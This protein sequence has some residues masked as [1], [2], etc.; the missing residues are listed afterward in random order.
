MKTRLLLLLLLPSLCGSAFGSSIGADLYGQ[1]LA[2]TATGF[3]VQMGEIKTLPDLGFGGIFSSLPSLTANASSS[4]PLLD[5]STTTASAQ[6]LI[7]G[8]ATPHSLHAFAEG[9]TN[10]STDGTLDAFVEADITAAWTDVITVAA[11]LPIGTLVTLE[12]KE[13]SNSSL[14]QVGEFPN[15]FPF[16][17]AVVGFASLT[18]TSFPVNSGV[19]FAFDNEV[20][21]LPGSSPCSYSG[22]SLSG[23]QDQTVTFVARV[24]DQ[25]QVDMQLGAGINFEQFGDCASTPTNCGNPGFTQIEANGL[26][27]L[28]LNIDVLTPGAYLVT[29]SGASYASTP[30]PPAFSLLIVGLV[31]TYI[32]GGCRRRRTVL[33]REL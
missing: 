33:S 31:A 21:C 4:L 27:T 20:T 3:S 1:V 10:R 19:G 22:P 28:D 12:V 16:T 9:I 18:D 13:H 7:M 2:T 23:S 14:L 24:G 11:N 29:G 30:E 17:D 32:T 25:L 5:G 26:N 15:Q 6:S 8:S